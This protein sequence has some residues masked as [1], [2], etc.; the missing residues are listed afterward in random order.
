VL[1]DGRQVATTPR[2][3]YRSK[4]LRPGRHRVQVIGVDRRGQASTLSR[5]QRFTVRKRKRPRG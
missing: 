2:T 4:R 3:R 5:S 1:I